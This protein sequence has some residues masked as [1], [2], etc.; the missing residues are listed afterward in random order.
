M[1]G[2]TSSVLWSAYREDLCSGRETNLQKKK[3]KRSSEPRKRPTVVAAGA[4]VEGFGSG[5]GRTDEPEEIEAA[6]HFVS[7]RRKALNRLLLNILVDHP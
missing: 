2:I 3:K 1:G 5:E 7:H 6:E 4:Q